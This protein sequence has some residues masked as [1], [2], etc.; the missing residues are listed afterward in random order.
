MFE[1]ATFA[2]FPSHRGVSLVRHDNAR[3]CRFHDSQPIPRFHPL[4][5][6]FDNITTIH[7]Q[8]HDEKQC[9]N[10]HHHIVIEQALTKKGRKRKRIFRTATLLPFFSHQPS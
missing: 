7:N 2:P 9:S 1:A 8:D 6:W 4:Q 10:D 5:N 3:Q